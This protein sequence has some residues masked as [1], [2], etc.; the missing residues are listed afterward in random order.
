MQTQ[1]LN[2]QTE[3]DTW[4]R[5]TKG[6]VHDFEN[7]LSNINTVLAHKPSQFKENIEPNLYR[8]KPVRALHSDSN[9]QRKV[10]RETLQ[11]MI[12]AGIK[13]LRDTSLPR[14]S[15]RTG[16]CHGYS[17]RSDGSDRFSSPQVYKSNKPLTNIQ[18]FNTTKLITNKKPS[19]PTSSQSRHSRQISDLKPM[20]LKPRRPSSSVQR[21]L[22]DSICT[23]RRGRE[24]SLERSRRNKHIY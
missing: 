18:E 6:L 15:Q 4:T 16:S 19:R 14:N 2:L 3:I 7:L 22:N 5:K 17:V 20:K 12:K 1:H 21:S 9:S 10:N 8:T 24:S 23:K 13:N 11:T